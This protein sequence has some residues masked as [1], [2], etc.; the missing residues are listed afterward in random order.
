M[1]RVS[2]KVISAFLA[3]LSFSTVAYGSE[4]ALFGQWGT[5]TQCA[6]NLITPKGTKLAAPFEISVDWL[7]HD[8]VWCRLNWGAVSTTTDGL[9]AHAQGLCGEDAVRDYAIR[10]TLKGGELT[11]TWNVFHVTGPLRRCAAH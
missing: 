11:L 1:Y 10:F 6:R 5:E 4:Q 2:G 9:T 8:D 7:G 3:F